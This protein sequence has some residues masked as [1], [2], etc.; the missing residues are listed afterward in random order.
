MPLVHSCDKNGLRKADWRSRGYLPHFDGRAIPQ[1]I[2][3]RLFDSIPDAVLKR[4]ARELDIT[5]SKHDQILLQTRIERYLDQGLWRY[6]H[7]K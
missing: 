4:W 7:E 5:K 1:S 6:L 2:T 3:L